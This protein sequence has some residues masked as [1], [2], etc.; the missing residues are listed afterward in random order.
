MTYF[1]VPSLGAE[2]ALL[3]QRSSP[4]ASVVDEGQAPWDASAV[5]D[6]V[7]DDDEWDW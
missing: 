1:G 3:K 6:D 4:A 7:G 2:Y 5:G